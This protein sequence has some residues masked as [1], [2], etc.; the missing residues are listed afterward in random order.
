MN[1]DNNFGECCKCPAKM[2]DGRLFTNYLL[3]SKLN[4]FIKDV[5]SI[6]TEH[7]YRNF[8]QKNGEKMINNERTFNEK[9]KRCNFVLN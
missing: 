8:L 4:T 2:S 3:N 1:A 9:H 7:E 5:N 6:K